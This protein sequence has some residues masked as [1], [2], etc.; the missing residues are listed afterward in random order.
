MSYMRWKLAS[1]WI[2]RPIELRQMECADRSLGCDDE[3]VGVIVL[4]PALNYA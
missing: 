1:L 4:D 2:V 3:T